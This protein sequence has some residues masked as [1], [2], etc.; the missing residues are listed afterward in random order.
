MDYMTWT[1]FFRRLVMNPSYYE[2][3]DTDHES[4]NKY[5]SE[6]V[7]KA[8]YELET[9]GC[10]EIDEVFSGPSV[11]AFKGWRGEVKVECSR[12]LSSSNHRLR[13]AS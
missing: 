5:L 3:E 13:A 6:L 9:S 2:L 12:P 10:L 4:I 1:Y 11:G 7:E 8:T